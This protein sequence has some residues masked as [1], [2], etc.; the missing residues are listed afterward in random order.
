MKH[1]GHIPGEIVVVDFDGMGPTWT[2]LVKRG[3]EAFPNATH[4]II[5]DAD[6]T[7]RVKT[8]N[9]MDLD[10]TCS[11]HH[12]TVRLP[13]S[14]RYPTCCQ[15]PTECLVQVVEAD[16]TGTR[17]I[18]WI[19]RN[20]PGARVERRTHQVPLSLCPRHQPSC[21]SLLPLFAIRVRVTPR[22]SWA[23]LRPPCG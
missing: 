5:S 2:V 19:Y 4:G 18:D 20:I 14:Y 22:R 11:K 13:D 15:D 8:L 21:D 23:R 6:F 9:K 12:Y 10:I 3:I 1:V 7:P 16:R 17:T